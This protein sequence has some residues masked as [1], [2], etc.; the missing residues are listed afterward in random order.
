M[1]GNFSQPQRSYMFMT[2]S[3]QDASRCVAC[4]ACEKKCPQQIRIIDQLKTA[5]EAL[6]GWIE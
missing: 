5:H 3:A 2:R 4:G 1:F 6:R